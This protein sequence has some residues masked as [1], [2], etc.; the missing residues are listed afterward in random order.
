[1]I[2]FSDLE[3]QT[4]Y[5][6]IIAKREID[7]PSKEKRDTVTYSLIDILFWFE[8]I[9]LL[10]T[11][12]NNY[13]RISRPFNSSRLNGTE[14]YIDPYSIGKRLFYAQAQVFKQLYKFHKQ[15]REIEVIP[16]YIMTASDI[17]I[18]LRHKVTSN[19]IILGA[20]P[21]SISSVR[22]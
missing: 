21:S 16:G 8:T 11:S 10:L 5:F 18:F 22:H 15:H 13:T 6:W 19:L 1:M 12:A 3:R 20:L 7:S 14:G 4:R 9:A 17:A 2:Y